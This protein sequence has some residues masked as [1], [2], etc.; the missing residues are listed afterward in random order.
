MHQLCGIFVHIRESGDE[1]NE[2]TITDNVSNKR[3][4][5]HFQQ[6]DRASNGN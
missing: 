1:F 6:K 5:A 2:A 3:N 4:G